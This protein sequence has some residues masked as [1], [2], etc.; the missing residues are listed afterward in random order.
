MR[1]HLALLA[2]TATGAA[3]YSRS[4]SPACPSRCTAQPSACGCPP[5]PSSCGCIDRDGQ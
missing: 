3:R 5:A 2:L 1:P 4:S